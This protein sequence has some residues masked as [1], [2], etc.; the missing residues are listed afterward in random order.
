MS[1]GLLSCNHGSFVHRAEPALCALPERDPEDRPPSSEVTDQD[2][3]CNHDGDCGDGYCVREEVEGD[4]VHRCIHPCTG[5]SD[6]DAG[7]ICICEPHDRATTREGIILGECRPATCVT[8]QECGAGF[9]CRAPVPENRRAHPYRSFSCQ[10][11]ADECSGQRECPLRPEA[12]DQLPVCRPS[13]T[14][15]HLA[16]GLEEPF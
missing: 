1:A 5:D 11:V 10:K 2:A 4:L 13:A 12:P 9:F 3:P 7:T 15:D 14:A 16:C 8:D 6:C